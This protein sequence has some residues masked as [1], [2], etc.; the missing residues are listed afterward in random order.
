MK[1]DSKFSSAFLKSVSEHPRESL[2]QFE[3]DW[4]GSEAGIK[5]QNFGSRAYM[6]LW[7]QNLNARFEEFIHNAESVAQIIYAWQIIPINK[8][9]PNW[10]EAS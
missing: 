7:E 5:K 2:S 3:C 6:S 9:V 4:Q 10:I 8:I 1:V